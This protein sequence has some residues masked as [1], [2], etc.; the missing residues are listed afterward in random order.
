MIDTEL[1]KLSNN[2]LDRFLDSLTQ[3]QL[4]ALIQRVIVEEDPDEWEFQPA[5]PVEFI[6]SRE[7]CNL[8]DECAQCI[9]DD[10]RKIFVGPP[11]EW[12][13]GTVI[14]D[15]AIGCGKS[16]ELSLMMAYITHCLLCLRRPA[17]FFLKR[18]PDR[19]ISPGSKLTIV[20]TSLNQKNAR[21]IVF[22][23]VQEKIVGN[24]WFMTHY[25]PDQRVKTE[26]IFDPTPE[27]N[28]LR[29]RAIEE[30][31]VYKNVCIFPGSSSAA[32]VV[33]YDVFCGVVDEA[34]LFRTEHGEDKADGVFEALTRRI[35]S[36]FGSMGMRIMAGSPMYTEDFL[37]RKIRDAR[38]NPID[39]GKKI[40]AIRRTSWD[41]HYPRWFTEKKP[42]FHVHTE[43]FEII[44]DPDT[45]EPAN[46][47]WVAIPKTPEYLSNFKK[48]PQGAM[49]DLAA[50][51]TGA[52]ARFFEDPRVV[53]QRV[54]RLRLHPILRDG[55]LRPD[56]VPTD[57]ETW[58][59]IHIDMAM[60]GRQTKRLDNVDISSQKAKK[61]D[62][63]GIAMA[64]IHGEN[65]EGQ[66]IYYIDLMHRLM[67]QV[68][69]RTPRGRIE[70]SAIR[71]REIVDWCLVLRSRGFKIGKVTIDGFQSEHLLQTLEDK[72]FSVAYVS[73][74]RS[75]APYIDLKESILE[76]RIDY[77][78]HP[79][80]IKEMKDLERVAGKKIDHVPGGSKDLADAVAGACHSLSTNPY[81]GPAQVSVKRY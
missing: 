48:N 49:R 27:S 36:R 3:E 39:A 57:P 2:E 34:T 66:S 74:D 52:L 17:S 60:G 45:Y 54:N 14:L 78:Y 64:H 80:F 51:P 50:R 73:V 12:E 47:R 7:Y 5:D 11:L 15:G 22:S 68:E 67:G 19:A 18:N 32:S 46:D 23:S 56:F 26:M 69:R 62:A 55:T 10:F 42:V 79:V 38:L 59:N 58:H 6:E 31:R 43:T 65:P 71:M 77:Y 28:V 33:G 40:Y 53:E 29:L 61:H 4:K 72:G 70:R 16:Y 44:E 76:G 30:G 8:K 81:S 25:P 75:T 20:N 35:T 37:E 9:K 41:R 13:T 24:R 1:H 21:K 63:L